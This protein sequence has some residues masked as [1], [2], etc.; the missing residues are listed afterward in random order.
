MNSSREHQTALIVNQ[1]VMHDMILRESI[2]KSIT[3]HKVDE[4][5]AKRIER[6]A[7]ETG[8]SVSRTVKRLL[9]EA[10]G[11]KPCRPGP[12]R[13]QFEAFFD[14]WSNDD[15]ERFSSSISDMERVDEE[16][17]R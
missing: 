4:Q 5:L 11:M 8:T 7:E 16:E 15:L 10:L 9:E 1:I 14:V 3:I 13:E 12:N 2:M 6:E 17:W